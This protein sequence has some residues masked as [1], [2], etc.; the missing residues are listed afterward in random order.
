MPPIPPTFDQFPQ[1]I[2]SIHDMDGLNFFQQN[3]RS[4]WL[5]HSV[6]VWNDPPA[7][8]TAL[9]NANCRVIVRLNNGY[10]STGTIP[11]P[12]GYDAFAA[13]CAQWVASSHGAK[14]FIVGNEMN[15]SAE[16]PNGQPILPTDYASCFLKCRAAIQAQPGYATAHV[17]PGAIGPYNV[18]TTYTG[19][20]TGDWVKYFLDVLTLLQGQCDGIAI[21]CYSRGQNAGDVTNQDKFPAPYQNNFRGFLAYQNFM[22]AIP[23]AMRNLPV[24]I[25]ETQP[26]INDAPNWLNQNSGWV[27]AAFAEINRWNSVSS[28]QPIQAL[29]MFRWLNTD[30]HWC[31]STKAS[32]LDDFRN[33]LAQNFKLRLPGG[34]Q[35]GQTLEQAVLA[36]AKSVPWMPVNNT[37]ALWKFAKAHGLQDQQSDELPMTFQG[38]N[39]IV[40]VFNLGIVYVKVGDWGNIKVIPK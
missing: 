27:T 21:H 6:D 3:Q 34:V 7:N 14:I 17:V 20:P 12:S 8:Y 32:V 30:P 16:R 19:N 26:L 23:N 5:V 38:E 15:I 39:Y 25:T 2:Y 33:A 35:P 4:G 29:A 18:E 37:A 10:G 28:N 24:Y 31:F 11:L 1:T 13:K 40:Q 36:A 22:N 9:V